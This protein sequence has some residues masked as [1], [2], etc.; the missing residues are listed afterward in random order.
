MD[1]VEVIPIDA[2]MLLFPLDT[3]AAVRFAF[4]TLDAT[5]ATGVAPFAR[6]V[7]DHNSPQEGE[8][9]MLRNYGGVAYEK[10]L[11]YLASH[12]CGLSF[13]GVGLQY[14]GDGGTFRLLTALRHL[15]HT[16]MVGYTLLIGLLCLAASL[17]LGLCLPL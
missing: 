13:E 7:I 1:G 9:E 6:A 14:V 16:T 5:L 4:I 12:D 2:Y 3:V 10:W 17:I 8:E 11:T 15:C